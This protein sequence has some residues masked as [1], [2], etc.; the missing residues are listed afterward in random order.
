MTLFSDI[1]L[2]FFIEIPKQETKVAIVTGGNAGIGYETVKGL[3]QAGVS[4]IM[5]KKMHINE[6]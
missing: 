2:I 5:G 1:L 4:V 6:Y 3:C